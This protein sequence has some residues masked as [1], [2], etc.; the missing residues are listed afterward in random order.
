MMVSL[1]W[2]IH[3]S[4]ASYFSFL[5]D[6]FFFFGRIFNVRSSR[7]FSRWCKLRK[8]FNPKMWNILHMGKYSSSGRGHCIEVVQ[9]SL[10]QNVGL[11]DALAPDL[12]FTGTKELLRIP[13]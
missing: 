9:N 13:Y 12:H 5:A 7:S 8:F 2:H 1:R 6:L 3:F 4:P 10:F 11:S